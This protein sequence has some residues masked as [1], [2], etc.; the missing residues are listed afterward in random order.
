MFV[1]FIALAR[2]AASELF[3]HRNMGY[4][5]VNGT[6]QTVMS[7]F[8]DSTIFAKVQ[9]KGATVQYRTTT[10]G[11]YKDI[12]HA[13]KVTP[14]TEIKIDAT[15]GYAKVAFVALDDNVCRDE[16]I[17][18]TKHTDVFELN[19]ASN[20]EKCVFYAPAAP[21]LQFN[22]ES[23]K[24]DDSWDALTVY[25]ERVNDVWYDRYE[26]IENPSGWSAI[27]E[28]PWL[29]KLKTVRQ[30]TNANTASVRIAVKCSEAAVEGENLFRETPVAA[31]PAKHA[32]LQKEI[33]IPVVGFA[34]PSILLVGWIYAFVR[35]KMK[36]PVEALVSEQQE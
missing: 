33:A 15:G 36:R 29:F 7:S 3:I 32:I 5:E 21:H 13:V 12:E 1:C 30:V 18:S 31:E 28:R 19:A 26:T 27:S 9:A 22:V 4:F 6:S 20:M 8:I 17:V 25:H 14:N 34:T 10:S 2:S 23:A 24:M 11:E 16:F 35:L